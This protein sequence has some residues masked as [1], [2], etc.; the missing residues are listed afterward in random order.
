MPKKNVTF[1][2]NCLHHH[3]N[4]FSLLAAIQFAVNQ[5]ALPCGNAVKPLC[6]VSTVQLAALTCTDLQTP[7]MLHLTYANLQL[8]WSIPG[9]LMFIVVL[10]RF[11]YRIKCLWHLCLK[12]N[13][14]LKGFFF[15]NW[16]VTFTKATIRCTNSKTR[17][18]QQI[19]TLS[20]SKSTI[21]SLIFI[22]FTDGKQQI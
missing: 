6:H 1:T 14:G 2:T 8:R 22:I 4:T 12:K 15:S 10:Y 18:D 19:E 3:K 13:T 5:S 11:I 9:T 21:T 20:F 7:E 16:E 17:P